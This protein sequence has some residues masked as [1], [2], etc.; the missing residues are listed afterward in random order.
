MQYVPNQLLRIYECTH[1][2][3]RYQLIGELSCK[4]EIGVLLIVVDVRLDDPLQVEGG[5]ATALVVQLRD[6]VVRAVRLQL[7][8][9]TQ[10]P[11]T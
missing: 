9:C 11:K 6:E 4:A 5:E 10:K 7:N 3:W 1:I 8:V 2:I